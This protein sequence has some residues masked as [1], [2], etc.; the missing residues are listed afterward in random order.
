MQLCSIPEP[1]LPHLS[2]NTHV[3]QFPGEANVGT[4]QTHFLWEP[5][6]RRAACRIAKAKPRTSYCHDPQETQ[7]LVE[8]MKLTSCN[9]R[10]GWGQGP[11]HGLHLLKLQWGS[12]GVG[13]PGASGGAVGRHRAGRGRSRLVVG[14]T[15]RHRGWGPG[16]WRVLG[17]RGTLPS[18][19]WKKRSQKEVDH[20]KGARRQQGEPNAPF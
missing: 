5:A 14:R 3:F 6:R 9:Q 18:E 15:E 2:N 13:Q 4:W 12:F 11:H 19:S 16:S 10:G 8:N 17:E 7:V 20:T 1:R